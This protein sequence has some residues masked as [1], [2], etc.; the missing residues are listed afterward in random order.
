VAVAGDK[1]EAGPFAQ[2]SPLIHYLLYMDEAFN[3]RIENSLLR[4]RLA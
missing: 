3:L 2:H 1:E 4:N